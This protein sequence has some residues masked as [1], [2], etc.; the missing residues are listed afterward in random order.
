MLWVG[1]TPIP[2]AQ[3]VIGEDLKTGAGEV[4]FLL[5]VVDE[6]KPRIVD[7]FERFEFVVY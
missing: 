4:P 2:K 1:N 7:E 3:F 5:G 6:T